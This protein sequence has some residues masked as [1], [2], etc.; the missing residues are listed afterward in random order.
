M[1]ILRSF[2]NSSVRFTSIRLVLACLATACLKCIN[3][4]FVHPVFAR[5]AFLQRRQVALWAMLWAT[6]LCG[7][8]IMTATA[9]ELILRDGRKIEGVVETDGEEYV[10]RD[11]ASAMRIPKYEVTRI[12]KKL[13]LEQRYQNLLAVT[14]NDKIEEQLNLAKWCRQ[15]NLPRQAKT[16]FARAVELDP[17]NYEARR[18]A[19]FQLYKGEWKTFAEVQRAT[20]MELYKGEWLPVATVEKKRAEEALEESREKARV[21]VRDIIRLARKLQP[22]EDNT[23]ISRQLAAVNGPNVFLLLSQEAGDS[24]LQVRD[25]VYRAL[26]IRHD[27]DGLS[28]LLKRFRYEEHPRLLKT[29]NTILA[30]WQPAEVL[31][32]KLLDMAIQAPTKKIRLR[33]WPLLRES[34]DKRIISALIAE[35]DFCPVPEEEQK[36]PDRRKLNTAGTLSSMDARPRKA[37]YPAHQLLMYLTNQKFAPEQKDQWQAWWQ[38]HQESFDFKN[39]PP[40]VEPRKDVPG[41]KK[42]TLA[43]QNEPPVLKKETASKNETLTPKTALLPQ[44]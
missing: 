3:F 13:T 40:T 19:G 22:G 38:E 23:A 41:A 11:G 42:E 18:G 8:F 20:G 35:V 16:H 4:A 26:G 44:P 37:F 24:N 28:L 36:R 1:N 12:E 6:M 10:I 7:I 21:A 27:A 25:T 33:A 30:A 5:P 43:P 15:N 39:P 31:T 32:P 34:G 2:S 29:L 9:D 17:A 14:A